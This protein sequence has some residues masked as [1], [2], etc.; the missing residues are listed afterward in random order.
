MLLCRVTR[1]GGGAR[2]DECVRTRVWRR[3]PRARKWYG[4]HSTIRSRARVG[5]YHAVV[6]AAQSA[7]RGIIQ[8]QG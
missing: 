8:S 2:N 1:G 4:T 6:R 3:A 5:E 7:V